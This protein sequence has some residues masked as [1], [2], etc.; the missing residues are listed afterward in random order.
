MYDVII[1]NAK[2]VSPETTVSGDV[3]IKGERIAALL[4]P[5]S[6]APASP[7]LYP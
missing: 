3:A 7:A 2:I 5:E 1:R 4:E 6:G